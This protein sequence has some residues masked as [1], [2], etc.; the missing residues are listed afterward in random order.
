METSPDPAPT[1][2]PFDLPSR[3][4]VVLVVDLVESVALMTQDERGVIQRWQDFVAHVQAV[5][6]PSTSG[7]LVKSLGDGLMIE[8]ARAVDG[9][10]A[11]AAMHAWMAGRCA[12]L[13]DGRRLALRAG[14]HAA[15]IFDASFDIY[16]VGVNL[17]A[18]IAAL[19]APGETVATVEVRDL[20][21]DS[22]DAEIEDLGDCHLRHV[23]RPVRIYR[24]GP[25]GAACSMPNH[26]SYAM[27][28]R[29][30][31][32]VI[33]FADALSGASA[34]GIGDI[35]ADGLIG[36]LSPS[37]GLHLVSRLSTALFRDQLESLVVIAARLNVRYVVSG[38]YVVS[39]T[40]VVVAAELADAA[41]GHVVW[42]GRARGPL[43]D[44]LTVDSELT[45][46][47]A[48]GIH[49]AVLEGAVAKAT[50]WPL[51]TLRSYE[52]L[53]GGISMM[54]RAS[55][56]DFATSRR[57]LESLVERH[58]RIA[59]PHA[60]LGK[61]HVLQ[62][63]QG[64]VTDLPAAASQALSHTHRALD[65]EPS[66][67]LA[68]AIEGFVYC[69]LKKDLATAG[70]RLGEAC[71]R[72]PSEGFAWL[73]LSVVR[74]FQGKPEPAL[75]A[76]RLALDLSPMDPLRYYYESLM[77]SC[78]FSAGRFEEAIRW[79]ERSRRRNR[80]HLSTLRILIAAYDAAGR[81]DEARA[82]AAE[83]QALRPGYR[84]ATYE[85][86]SVAALYP[87]GQRIAAAMRRAGLP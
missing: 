29:A 6:L 16:G 59:L 3:A 84:V 67:A 62:A 46:D 23:N 52:L 19:A 1:A 57:L 11:A 24:L 35:L 22:L 17:A 53:L 71:E 61:W 31:I 75:E 41:T 40:D 78:E 80:Q 8:F 58:G 72:N 64:T 4:A 85:A 74:A 55:A 51:P 21:R 66:S 32:A 42:S 50:S 83:L 30:S 20:L 81:G 47:L 44:L 9:V 7:R 76:A 65:L 27:D 63:I 18:R 10:T 5:V 82:V 60:W 79:C 25:A 14:L 54:H 13:A 26:E 36:R 87:F 34:R 49:R 69:H 77:G 48:D 45:H 39:N 70:D 38:T 2:P 37:P 28:L 15:D 33:P 68:L 43:G 86:T 73:F 56:D 12:P